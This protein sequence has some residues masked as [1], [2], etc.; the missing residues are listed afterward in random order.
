MLAAGMSTPAQLAKRCGVSRQAAGRWLAMAEA[1][2]PA[3]RLLDIANRLKVRALWLI[4]G[5]GPMQPMPEVERIRVLM[6]KLSKKQCEA[7]LR[8]GERMASR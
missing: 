7:W 3:T 4:D 2:I 5:D 8:F 6:E 1:E